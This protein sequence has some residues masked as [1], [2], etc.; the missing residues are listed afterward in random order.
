MPSKRQAGSSRASKGLPNTRSRTRTC[1]ATLYNPDQNTQFLSHQLRALGLYAADIIGD[2]NCLFRALSD[3][4]WGTQSH[5]LKLREEVCDWIASRK[6][7]YAPF[8]DDD[9]GLDVHLRCMRTPGTYG[10]HLELSAFAHCRRRDV[11]VIQPGL[12]Y[13]IE[14]NTGVNDDAM[15]SSAA[16]DAEDRERR[17]LRRTSQKHAASKPSSSADE[18]EE[19]AQGTIYVAYHDW[20]HF[21]SVRNV[22]G[23]HNGIPNV[24]EMVPEESSSEPPAGASKHKL[25]QQAAL[26]RSTR[27]SGRLSVSSTATASTSALPTPDVLVTPSLHTPRTPPQPFDIPLPPSPPDSQS[28]ESSPAT[29][30]STSSVGDAASTAPSSLAVSSSPETTWRMNLRLRP[31][32]SRDARSPKRTLEETDPLPASPAVRKRRRQQSDHAEISMDVDADPNLDPG[33]D[34]VASTLS[35]ASSLTSLSS[36]SE[37]EVDDVASA[38]SPLAPIA[39]ASPPRPLTRRQRKALGLPKA[40]PVILAKV[41]LP[42]GKHRGKENNNTVASA[43]TTTTKDKEP[44]AGEWSTNGVG[45]LDVRGFRELRI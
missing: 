35:D 3:Q 9:R 16:D 22:S 30:L 6:D 33:L 25:K 41:K 36:D 4:L 2:G 39:A 29:Q 7:R 44:T 17:R 38:P 45:R 8:V 5:H 37:H 10:G 40:R 34:H 20:E 11:K 21:S 31:S 15:S 19:E 26:R 28:R 42:N 32:S 23:P 12:V 24:R 18:P 13:I 27:H 1:K 43:I 14:W